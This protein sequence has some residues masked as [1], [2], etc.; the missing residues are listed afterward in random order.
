MFSMYRGEE[1]GLTHFFTAVSD[2]ATQRELVLSVVSKVK[3]KT[4]LSSVN[5]KT[6]S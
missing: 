3:D 1:R 4:G 2:V 5:N 6:P